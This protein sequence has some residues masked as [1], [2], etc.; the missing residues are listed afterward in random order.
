MR[1]VTIV[2]VYTGLP[3][4]YMATRVEI[5]PC[6]LLA[7]PNSWDVTLFGTDLMRREFPHRDDAGMMIVTDEPVKIEPFPESVFDRPDG[8]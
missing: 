1:L 3:E 4:T 6:N 8:Y 7:R 2:N 5:A